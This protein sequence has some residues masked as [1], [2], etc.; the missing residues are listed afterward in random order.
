MDWRLDGRWPQPF[1]GR[2]LDLPFFKM[3]RV[4]LCMCVGGGVG[5]GGCRVRCVC[6]TVRVWKRGYEEVACVDDCLGRRLDLT[7]F[8]MVCV[9]VSVE[10]G[11]VACVYVCACQRAWGMCM[12]DVQHACATGHYVHATHT[13][14]YHVLHRSLIG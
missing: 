11:V 10:E 12:S 1:L 3:V 9:R 2:I 13:L 8:Q 14:I 6:D 4:R 7:F 5:M